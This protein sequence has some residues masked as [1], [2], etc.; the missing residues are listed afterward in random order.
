MWQI[1]LQAFYFIVHKPVFI[2]LI[3]IV[4]L[5]FTD[6]KTS[7]QDATFSDPINNKTYFHPGVSSVLKGIE[8]GCSAQTN[9]VGVQPNPKTGFIYLNGSYKISKKFYAAH[10]ISIL[11]DREGKYPQINTTSIKVN[12]IN[13][14]WFYK[15]FEGLNCDNFLNKPFFSMGFYL[16]M[17]NKS[18]NTS[19]LVFSQQIADW[20]ATPI[21]SSNIELYSSINKTD[22]GGNIEFR[23]PISKLFFINKDDWSG[24]L[25]YSVHHLQSTNNRIKPTEASFVILHQNVVLPRYH[26]F[27]FSILSKGKL[28]REIFIQYERQRPI[29]RILTGVNVFLHPQ[30]SLTLAASNHTFVNWTKNINSLI[31]TANLFPN[32]REKGRNTSIYKLFFSYTSVISGIGISPIINKY[33]SFQ[34]GI[35]FSK[36][37]DCNFSTTDCPVM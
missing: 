13:L 15:K 37:Y 25:C 31:C 3:T 30:L 10:G 23:F 17:F 27:T 2:M 28:N 36:N 11:N 16:G 22:M 6:T 21:S 24:S 7:A 26:I 33:G 9:F 1:K 18:I 32:K 4:C 8:A 14:R 19:D 5:I 12:M 29:Q 35:K 20:S 34:I